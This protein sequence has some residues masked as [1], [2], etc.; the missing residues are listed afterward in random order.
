VIAGT[1]AIC[2]TCPGKR[3]CCSRVHAQNGVDPPIAFPREAGAIAEALNC[4]PSDFS[5]ADETG[6]FR[7][8]K[9]TE[10]GCFF[11][12]GGKCAIYS[13]RP[14]DCRLFP[15]DIGRAKDGKLVWIVYRSVCPSDF[16]PQPLLASARI[17]LR[18][19]VDELLAYATAKKPLLDQ[20]DYVELG[21]VTKEELTVI[22]SGMETRKP[23]KR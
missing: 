5:I 4:P 17:F 12:R 22:T 16:D 23:A 10:S 18:I 15:L 13:V 6:S 11:F 21:E 3:N 19:S 9:S 2:T 14:L 1:F 7:W 20:H 8:L